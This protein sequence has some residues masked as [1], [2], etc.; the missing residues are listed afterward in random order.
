MCAPNATK[1]P[2][3]GLRQHLRMHPGIVSFCL[4][5]MTALA[6]MHGDSMEELK[7]A[8]CSLILAAIS[9]DAS[10]QRGQGLYMKVIRDT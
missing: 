9:C 4:N 1:S 10:N 8:L 6:L 2:K 5:A 7:L 3:N